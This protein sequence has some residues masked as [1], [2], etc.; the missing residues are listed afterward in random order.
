[1]QYTASDGLFISS[2]HRKQTH[3]LSLLR[4]E[5]FVT[6]MSLSRSDLSTDDG[7]TR[8]IAS[9]QHV[10]LCTSVLGFFV[11]LFSLIDT[12]E[13]LQLSIVVFYCI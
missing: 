6:I 4:S 5:F 8:A 11:E 13:Q 3:E 12:G 10:W 1:M 9:N 7:V 2:S